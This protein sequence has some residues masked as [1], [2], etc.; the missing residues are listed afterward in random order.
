MQ[1]VKPMPFK[2]A[3]EKLGDKTLIGSKLNSAEWSAVPVGLRDRA[4]FSSTV[5]SV[6]FLQRGRDFISDFLQNNREQLDNGAIALKAGSR[7]QFVDLLSKFAQAEG[8]GPLDPDD[9]GTLKDIT[10]QK[11]LSLIFNTMTQSANDFGYWKQGMDPDVLNEFPAQRFIRVQDVSKP[12]ELHRQNEGVVELK[13]NVGFWTAM[14]DP[15]IGGFGVPWGPWGFNSGMDV[16]DVDRTESE[17]L[18][19]IKPGEEVAPVDKEFNDRL[20]AS[21]AGL[22]P[23]MIEKLQGAFGDQ[24]EVDGDRVRWSGKSGLP[25]NPE[26]V[27]TPEPETKKPAAPSIEKEEAT[28]LDDVLK[29]LDISKASTLTTEKVQSLIE[30]L[31]ESNPVPASQALREIVGAKTKGSLTEAKITKH[32]QDFIDF[33]PRSVVD[34]IGKLR[35]EVARLGIGVGGDYANNRVRLNADYLGG[36]EEEVRRVL[37]H[38]MMHWVHREG[39]AEYQRAIRQ[40]FEARTAGEKLVH[41]FGDS[42]GKT[43][44]WYDL[45]AGRIYP[46]EVVPAGLEIPTRYIE[47]LAKDPEW[48]MMR[49]NADPHFRE[50]FLIV[51]K[52]FFP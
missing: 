43:D 48:L 7:A 16:E 13:T 25:E 46:W 50:T 23:D 40:H 34:R 22:D 21:T 30:E 6:R 38:E 29:K 31:K 12:R 14:N 17:Q 5:E 18:G 51:L 27:V 44:K 9:A 3:V 42:Y 47:L 33:L 1:F 41:L 10:S 2:E 28:T 52:G 20:D 11:R 32:A 49:W 19:L 4:F 24:I 15:K 39:S 26:P 36:K 37:F 35:I 8:M 45:Y